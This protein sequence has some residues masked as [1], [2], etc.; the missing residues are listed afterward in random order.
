MIRTASYDFLLVGA[1]LFN[2]VFAHEATK[3]GKRCLVVEKREHLG[4]DLYCRFNPVQPL[5]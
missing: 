3:K 2:A 4:G 5:L 1:G